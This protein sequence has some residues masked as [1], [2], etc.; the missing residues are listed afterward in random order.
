MKFPDPISQTSCRK[1]S[2]ILRHRSQHIW[3]DECNK[4]KFSDGPHYL[5]SPPS[6]TSLLFFPGTQNIGQWAV[7]EENVRENLRS[8]KG[9][10]L[11][12]TWMSLKSLIR[13]GKQ[14]SELNGKGFP[15]QQRALSVCRG[16]G[17]GQAT[18][19][20]SER[21]HRGRLLWVTSN[22]SSDSETLGFLFHKRERNGRKSP[23]T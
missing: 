17:R 20:L 5:S 1:I 12:R 15:W 14:Q 9:I 13:V 23:P 22:V 10:H 11:I 2:T 18:Y 21:L 8:K 6:P 7:G 16:L 19:H 3:T 4:T